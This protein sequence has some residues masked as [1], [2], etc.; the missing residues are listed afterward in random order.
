M[1]LY[2]PVGLHVHVYKIIIPAAND[3]IP[4]YIV[5]TL[6]NCIHEIV[7]WIHKYQA[8]SPSSNAIRTHQTLLPLWVES[9]WNSARW[10]KSSRGGVDV[11]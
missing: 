3:I 10:V 11:V 5:D 9:G 1:E 8:M 6:C 2:Y 7:S 4:M